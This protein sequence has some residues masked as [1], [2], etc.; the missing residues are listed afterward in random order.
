MAEKSLLKTLLVLVSLLAV[1][2]ADPE[3]SCVFKENCMLPCQIQSSSDLVIHWSKPSPDGDSVVHSYYDGL[4]QLGQ[5]NQNF[6]GRTSL[7]LDQIS[8]GTASLM[9]K[10]VKI[11]DEG[12][13]KCNTSSSTGFKESFINLKIDAPVSTIRI[14]QD[15]NRITCSSEGI[16]PQPELTWSTEPP[17]NT[18]L[19]NRTTVHQTEEKLYD[20]SSSLT[21]PDGSDRTYSC[22]I[23]TRRNKMMETFKE[24]E[25]AGGL[26]WK[27]ILCLIGPAGA[28][29]V[30]VLK[31]KCNK[32][33]EEE[34][35]EEK[36]KKKDKDS[37]KEESESF[38]NF[39]EEP[40]S[41]NF[42]PS[43]E[44]QKLKDEVKQE[45]EN[46]KTS[47]NDP[48]TNGTQAMQ[49]GV[50]VEGIGFGWVGKRQYRCICR[51][52]SSIISLACSIQFSNVSSP[53]GVG[54]TP[55]KVRR[56][57]LT[58][59]EVSCVVKQSCILPCSFQ[60]YGE[61]VLHWIR[62]ESSVQR[63][64]SYYD[65]QDQLDLQDQNFRGRTSLFQDQISRGNASL[66]LREVKVQ[67]QGR[68]NCLITTVKEYKDSIIRLSVDAPVSDIRIHQDGNRI[69]CSSEGIYPPPELTWSTEPPS[70][71]TLHEST[72]IQ[73]TEDQLYNISSSLTV[74]DGSDRTY[75]CTI[76]TRRN[77]RRTTFRKLSSVT[78]TTDET[79]LP[80]LGLNGSVTTVV[81]RFDH[82]TFLN[83]TGRNRSV[84]ESWRK[85]VKDVSEHGD[86]RLQEVDPDLEGNYSCETSN[87]DETMVTQIA[88]KRDGKS[89]WI[90]WLVIGI[91]FM[92]VT[93]YSLLCFCY[94]RRKRAAIIQKKKENECDVSLILF[95]YENKS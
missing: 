40:D 7:I 33:K 93:F 67:D 9:L 68:Y 23:R 43:E 91:I 29:A 56:H 86:L 48:E 41:R 58:D 71:T 78:V 52:D 22:T 27:V 62:L 66:L 4:D 75:S 90:I 36:E 79:T 76:R 30:A 77:Q 11:Q 28:A 88:V 63:V 44:I 49:T 3:V 25:S 6:Q 21:G 15:G 87:E 60:S 14:H 70:N 69:T 42:N 5:Q 19:Q 46:I 92:I 80:C 73:E 24:K 32:K 10:E 20:I 37:K 82:Q 39:S 51:S 17:S 59:V 1:S 83:Q 72:R 45:L 12:R 38:G 85:H 16:Y 81:W 34:K 54:C 18:V 50:Y 61:P 35:D 53:G 84:S 26:T 64:H 13:Y 65:N 8:R 94:K 57:L 47:V 55:E 74:P 95:P 31:K 2:E 89:S